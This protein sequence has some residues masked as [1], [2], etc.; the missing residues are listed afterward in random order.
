[1]GGK[2]GCNELTVK[3][4]MLTVPTNLE[5]AIVGRDILVDCGV[6]KMGD[7]MY[8]IYCE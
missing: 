7:E 4:P 8:D 3:R 1:M 2:Y 6:I 5:R